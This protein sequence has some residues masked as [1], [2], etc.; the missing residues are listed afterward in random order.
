MLA[1]HWCYDGLDEASSAVKAVR[2]ASEREDGMVPVDVWDA[3]CPESRRMVYTVAPS[4]CAGA[5]YVRNWNDGPLPEDWK[6]FYA[7]LEPYVFQ[8]D[9]LDGYGLRAPTE[10][11]GAFRLSEPQP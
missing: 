1:W 7:A 2:E 9:T 10:Y 4:T 11:H 3:L 6:D 5:A 8:V